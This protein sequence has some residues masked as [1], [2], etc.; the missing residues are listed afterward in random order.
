M[1]AVYPANIIAATVDGVAVS[2]PYIVGYSNRIGGQPAECQIL[3]GN[4]V[5]ESADHPNSKYR[6]KSASVTIDGAA[7]ITGYVYRVTKRQSDRSVVLT[8]LD[9][10]WHINKTYI[11]ASLL[12]TLDGDGLPTTTN[13]LRGLGAD[14]VF[15]LGGKPN[16]SKT[17][18]D[19][20]QVGVDG[21]T[22]NADYWTYANIVDW[23]WTN[24]I[25]DVTKPTIPTT[26]GL[27]QKADE[28]SLFGVPV[29]D[30]LEEVFARTRSQW[31]LDG[32]NTA[33]IFD[34]DNPAATLAL[35]FPDPDS[36]SPASAHTLSVTEEFEV[37]E[38]IDDGAG[39][40]DIVGGPQVRE[41]M[42]TQGDFDSAN[43]N[44]V[45]AS[46]GWAETTGGIWQNFNFNWQS[47][48]TNGASN[49][50][51][52]HT[53][54]PTIWAAKKI[55]PNLLPH[56]K[57]YSALPNLLI[58]RDQSGQFVPVDS[59]GKFEPISVGE[60]LQFQYPDGFSLNLDSG[61]VITKWRSSLIGTPGAL[62]LTLP[63]AESVDQP[64]RLTVPYQCA[65]RGWVS[66][67]GSVPGAPAS[68]RRAVIR[69]EF[70]HKTR[71]AVKVV[72]PVIAYYVTNSLL[73]LV[74]DMASLPTG[75]TKNY[76]DIIPIPLVPGQFNITLPAGTVVD[77]ISPLNELK[78]L[79]TDNVGV[80]QINGQG[81]FP[82]WRVLLPG[83]RLTASP[84]NYALS[85]KEMVT[86][87]AFN[88]NTQRLEFSFT[89]RLGSDITNLAQA[90]VD[91]RQYKRP[92]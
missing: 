82:S 27:G 48:V 44:E 15:N 33:Y 22:T 37:E 57:S 43:Y 40:V 79:V 54:K 76:Q 32:S 9:K 74:S 10:R 42:L 18:L 88:D 38:S 49:G 16:K 5:L 28:L 91:T 34:I 84:N 41:I 92:L 4:A 36:P 65:H 66:V 69:N 59:E 21:A 17:S 67:S 83:T 87:I 30:A 78:T 75:A 52:I 29:G 85:G 90:F 23:I 12:E 47:N 73:F 70:V 14:V 24:Y 58:G 89:N 8:I 77:G 20:V 51:T 86:A 39:Q 62:F 53:I 7:L 68:L 46:P 81:A 2:A 55:G 63:Y 56:E 26:G 19:F 50:T 80:S 13:G 45:E 6:G 64:Y 31:V 72:M 71:E 61:H 3:L 25:T 60:N 1:G 35:T 11:G